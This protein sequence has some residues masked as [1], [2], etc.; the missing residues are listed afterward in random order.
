[1]KKKIFSILLSL[2]M[3]LTM[4]PVATGTVWAE[5]DSVTTSVTIGG[6]TLSAGT[7]YYRNGKD[8][9]VG[10]VN[11]SPEGANAT[12][13]STDGTLTLSGLNL[14]SEN[15]SATGDLTI[16]LE[17]ENTL[18]SE[19]YGSNSI[20]VTQ[21]TLTIKG[22]GS[23]TV[24]NGNNAQTTIYASDI[25][26][27][28]GAK[29]TATHA[30]GGAQA[31]HASGENGIISISGTGTDVKASHNGTSSNTS[32][33]SENYVALKAGTI[34]ISNGAKL[35]AKGE[36]KAVD[37]T[38]RVD[39]LANYKIYA[40]DSESGIE[41]KSD[42]T[43]LTDK[44]LKIEPKT[45]APT[46]LENTPFGYAYDVQRHPDF[47]STTN[48]TITLSGLRTNAGIGI[49]NNSG[50]WTIT[51]VG[52]YSYVESQRDSLKYNSILDSIVDTI[53]T[54]YEASGLKKETIVIHELKNGN[55][56]IAYGVVIAYDAE[57]N[58]A[59]FIGDKHNE[60]GA[61]YLLSKEAQSGS[62]TIDK[63]KIATDFVKDIRIKLVDT[64]TSTDMDPTVP[65]VF[66]AVTAGYDYSNLT[67]KTVTVTNIGNAETG[68]LKVAL[69]GGEAS[70]FTVTPNTINSIENTNDT[71]TFTVTPN[72][73]LE[74]GTHIATV[75]VSGQNIVAQS[76]NVSFTVKAKGLQRSIK[77][78][79]EGTYTFPTATVGYSAPTA[80][81]VTI[82]ST[83]TAATGKLIITLS[84][85]NQNSFTLN[86]T[87]IESIA[88]GESATFT[89]TPNTDLAAGTYKAEVTVG[90]G[91]LNLGSFNV[92][93]TVNKASSGGG[94]HS[95]IQKPTIIAG[96]GAETSLSI[97]GT[98]LTIKVTEGYELTDVILNGVSK[99][100]VT[101]LTGLRTGDKVE[102]KTEKKQEKPSKEEIIA[103]LDSS[104]L[105]ARSKL[106]TLENGKKAVR[107]TWYDQ[108]G[109]EIDFDGIEVYR[110][111]KRYKGYGLEP[112]YTTKGDKS[113]GY[114]VNT[115]DLKEGTT[116]Y[117]KV[118][119]YV[120]IDGQKYYTD[121]S[122]KAIR[123]IK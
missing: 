14:T 66:P 64:H 82:T 61:G 63:I 117:Y 29:V 23:L 101:E 119:G 24:N 57:K 11:D 4:M 51:K 16:K 99:G 86:K 7:P 39:N 60:D 75:T 73:G 106:I 123:T 9:A 54:N 71:A 50:S 2:C 34:Q 79:E 97:L 41:E 103:A 48:P 90:D 49:S 89:V 102:V 87:E 69:S 10:T 93:F 26:I 113:E 84:G 28:G 92:S 32:E 95:S 77:L 83:G 78:S 96:E 40:G 85:Q 116:Y 42:I 104:K 70:N 52:T 47:P 72:T 13:N 12:F 58:C 98:N 59:V 1:M 56:H 91:N 109:N 36:A 31:I 120:T 17:G 110:S 68:E 121:Y 21:G 62:V 81:E 44:Y 46:A 80:K 45:A 115:K 33:N 55:N 76:F 22:S 20:K 37:G 15:I 118:R 107:V 30:G 112:F 8:G 67:S 88:V 25:T 114:Y 94:S 3:V 43:N 100:K 65:Y 18:G 6:K 53:Y 105:V 38:L 122:L 27:N 35:T 74:E 5:G 19:S 108:N 111:V